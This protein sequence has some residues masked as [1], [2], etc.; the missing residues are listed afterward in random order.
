MQGIFVY[1]GANNRRILLSVVVLFFAAVLLV[2]PYYFIYRAV[3]V[4]LDGGT[5]SL[6]FVVEHALII[7]SLMILQTIL[8]GKGLDLS[9]QAAYGT[10][11]NLRRSLAEK[12]EKLPLGVIQ[13]KGV[14]AFKKI[15]TDDIESFEVLLAHALPEGVSNALSTFVVL[16]AIFICDWR[17]GLLVLAVILLGFV[18]V[19]LMGRIGNKGAADY[20]SAGRR[21]NNTI[22][23]YVNG[24]EVVKVFNKTGES[25]ARFSKAVN[26][27]R[28]YTLR[29][30]RACWPSMAAYQSILPCTLLF[31]LPVGAVLVIKNW[32]AL[33]E[34]VLAICLALGLS[35]PLLR[36]MS[37]VSVLPQIRYKLSEL[38]RVLDHAPLKEGA[39]S[40]TMTQPN[41]VFDR[42]SFSYE[43]GTEI[44]HDVTLTL[45]P[46]TKTAIVGES[47]AGKSTLAKLL[48]H[49]YDVTA[50]AVRIGGR[51]IRE[52][53]LAGLNTLVSYVSQDNFLFNRSLADNIRLGRPD[54]SDEE[55]L[56][57]AEAAQCM[58]FI[59]ALPQGIDTL[60][61]DCGNRLSGGERQRIT[62][63][64]ALLADTPVLV[65]D[66]A[67]A[68]SDAEHER[69]IEAV[70]KQ[71]CHRT[72]PADDTRCRSNLCAR[73]RSCS[74]CGD[75]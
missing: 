17:L 4:L 16:A 64:R 38:E 44:L 63:A 53:S 20:Y 39:F 43:D 29:W 41:V 32:V 9:H 5:F 1:G 19:L 62:L 15:F 31:A 6:A 25:Y 72:S 56:H 51:D 18:P 10:L 54:A 34:F 42:V 12:L 24:M 73:W 7:G 23:E 2:M 33:P 50:G 14:G 57:A 3:T 67:T 21:M 58:D 70:L 71:A 8:Y 47:G 45:A 75:A 13:E 46:G 11:M 66:E 60:A 37:F 22:I 40:E 65:L 61:G 68:F 35:A 26:E 30:Y 55:V 27:Y 36:T 28:D 74:G 69:Q 52:L 49:Y 59:E 48:V